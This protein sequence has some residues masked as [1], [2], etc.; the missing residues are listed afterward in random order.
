MNPST[1]NLSGKICLVTGA[2][3]GIGRAIALAFAESGAMVYANA[4]IEGCLDEWCGETNAG[5]PG[6]IVPIYFDVTDQRGAGDA[7]ARIRKQQGRLDVLVNNAAIPA[8]ANLGMISWEKARQVMEVNVIAVI[9][10]LQLGGRLMVRG[11]SGSIINL[12]STVG[13]E[14]NPGQCLYA[15]SKGAVIAL[16]KSA[17]KEWAPHGIRVNSV[18]PGLTRTDMLRE[19]T[20][21]LLAERVSRIRMGRIAEPHE[22]ADVC[23]FL[24]SDASAYV[25]GQVI[26]VDGSPML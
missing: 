9:H 13:L 15:A 26:A 11:K 1:F 12:S 6:G 16:T 14:G 2:G 7:L 22:I 19:S 18:A 20:P 5:L 23:C 21:E 3:R 4:R 8:S 17:A 25:T 10:L 24:A